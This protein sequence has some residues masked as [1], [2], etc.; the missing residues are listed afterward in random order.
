MNDDAFERTY[1]QFALRSL[2]PVLGYED[3]RPRGQKASRDEILDCFLAEPMNP[4][5]WLQSRQS[6]SNR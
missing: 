1:R 2:A 3:L 6:G 4:L 5:W